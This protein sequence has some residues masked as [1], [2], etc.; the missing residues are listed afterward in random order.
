MFVKA[1]G[2]HALVGFSLDSLGAL[3]QPNQMGSARAFIALSLKDIGAADGIVSSLLKLAAQNMGDAFKS[4][5]VKI[6]DAQGYQWLLGPISPVL[7]RVKKTL[8]LAPNLES[9]TE[10]LA[11]G[12][13]DS[14]LQTPEG[15][16]MAS[17]SAIFGTL[18]ELSGVPE[19]VEHQANAFLRQ[20]PKMDQDAFRFFMD[21]VKKQFGA[22]TTMGM[23]M[24]LD[25]GITLKSIGSGQL[26]AALIGVAAAIAI[27]AFVRYQKRAKT[28]EARVNLKTLSTRIALQHL[29]A[30][31]AKSAEGNA[32]KF[33]Q[34]SKLVP[35]NPTEFMCQ[36]GKPILFKPQPDTW[37]G[38]AWKTL[39]FS[40]QE[41]FR[42]A[43]QIE[44]KGVGKD[45]Q[46]TLR[47]I[48]D[49]DCDGRVST[50]EIKGRLDQRGHIDRSEVLTKS[51]ME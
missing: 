44:S 19:L 29:D 31:N 21:N 50:F 1:L 14:L 45:A 22:G 4:V 20:V 49:L 43:Y 51:E 16:A 32:F 12:Q 25:E 42:Y 27:P 17:P 38:V 40:I 3:Q 8:F 37:S 48:G 23:F 34:S 6:G 46:F 9:I 35:G 26:S 2:G 47:A 10:A 33:L 7:I 13:A 15:K 18:S 5:P 28:A 30:S 39:D 36:N 41:P 24:N 11:R